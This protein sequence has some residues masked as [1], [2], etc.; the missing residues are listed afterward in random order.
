MGGNKLNRLKLL[1]RTCFIRF[2]LIFY[3]IIVIVPFL[4]IFINSF[5]TNR[6]FYESIWSLPK[7]LNFSNYIMAFEQANISQYFVN[8]VIVCV[9]SVVLTLTLS[10]MVSY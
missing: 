7:E 6:E 3:A 5:K 4:M 8:T 2:S 9:I 1:G 10:T